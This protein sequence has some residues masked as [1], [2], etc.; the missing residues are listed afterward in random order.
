MNKEVELEMTLFLEFL[1]E[2]EE[3]CWTDEALGTL[4]PLMVDHIAREE[5]YDL[6]K[7]SLV[8]EI[9]KPAGAPAAPRVEARKGIV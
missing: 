1:R 5:L 6:T 8:S 3:L 7:L 9:R 2:L 4:K